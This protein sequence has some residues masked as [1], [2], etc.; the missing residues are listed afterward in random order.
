MLSATESVNH[1]NEISRHHF[2][3]HILGILPR[4][5]SPPNFIKKITMNRVWLADGDYEESKARVGKGHSVTIYMLE[6]R[7]KLKPNQLRA[8]RANIQRKKSQ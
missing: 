6:K 3:H 1:H 5:H 2:L 7:W 8:Y 4:A